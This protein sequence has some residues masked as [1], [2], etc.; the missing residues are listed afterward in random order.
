MCRRMARSSAVFRC[1][2]L[3][4]SAS[5]FEI[6]AGTKRSYQTSIHLSH[7]SLYEKVKLSLRKNGLTAAVVDW[8][9]AAPQVTQV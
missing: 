4:R 7:G 3:D 5:L 9:L 2:A 6:I 1:L 8:L